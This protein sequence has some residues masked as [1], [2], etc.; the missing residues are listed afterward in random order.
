[1]KFNVDLQA[2]VKA[3]FGYDVKVSSFEPPSNII[4]FGKIDVLEGG[5]KQVDGNPVTNFSK[6]GTPVFDYIKVQ[7]S[8]Y[9]DASGKEKTV[10]EYS[11]P[12][13]CVCEVSQPTIVEETSLAGK[14]AGTIKEI[15]G[16]DDFFITVRGFVINYDSSDYPTK[17][18]KELYNILNH[19]APLEIESPYLTNLFDITEMVIMDK[20]FPQVE[21]ALHYQPFEFIAKSNKPY[22]IDV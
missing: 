20:R 2:L 13:E 1:M 7:K 18:V 10:P 5:D 16:H 3:H 8:G 14:R 17:A 9:Y 12:F 19:P 15:I 21:G 6:L 22:Y 11:F 4:P